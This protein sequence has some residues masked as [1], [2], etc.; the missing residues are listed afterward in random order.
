MEKR[1]ERA[2]DFSSYVDERARGFSGRGWV[3]DELARWRADPAGARYFLLTGEPGCGKTAIAARLV[4]LSESEGRFQ[5]AVDAHHFCSTSNVG[6][7]APLTFVESLSSH[8]ARRHPT[9]S[10]AIYERLG[11]RPRIS[12]EQHVGASSG[13][14][15]NVSIGHLSVGDM[16][17]EDA[18]ARLI[19]EPLETLAR[20][21]PDETVLIAID[22]L[23]EALM[24]SGGKIIV[25][26]IAGSN[27]LPPNVRFV[28]TSRSVGH[29]EDMFFGAER[30]S[31]SS[32]ER[33]AQ[34][35]NDVRLYVEW[36]LAHDEALVPRAKVLAPKRLHE[37]INALVARADG[38]FL[39]ARSLLNALGQGHHTLEIP[40]TWPEDLDDSFRDSL[41]R[42][43]RLNQRDWPRDYAPIVGVLSVAQAPL[44]QAQLATFTALDETALWSFLGELDQFVEVIKPAA[45][46]MNE[47][48]E[49]S[50]GD[51]TGER[52]YRLYHQS[53]IDFLRRQWLGRGG[54]PRNKYYLDAEAWHRRI[55]EHYLASGTVDLQNI[56]TYGFE[57]LAIHLYHARRPARLISLIDQAW[58]ELRCARR[59]GSY[60]GFF[61]DVGLAWQA[62]LDTHA[63]IPTLVRLQAAQQ[64]AHD[65][66]Y[67]YDDDDLRLLVL[68]GRPEEALARAHDRRVP[69]LRLDCLKAT[70]EAMA[71]RGLQVAGVVTEMA[72]T[73]KAIKTSGHCRDVVAKLVDNGH[74]EEAQ[75]IAEIA[76]DPEERAFVLGLIGVALWRIDP[77]QGRVLLD[78][79]GFLARGIDDARERSQALGNYA[80]AL[81][82]SGLR[83]EACAA[84]HDVPD[85]WRRSIALGDVASLLFKAGDRQV[86]SLLEESR[87][88]ASGVEEL[89]I[90]SWVL[91]R[92]SGQFAEVGLYEQA[93]KVAQSVP[94][95]DERVRARCAVARALTDVG[96]DIGRDR[97]E[98]IQSEILPGPSQSELLACLVPSLADA[99]FHEEAKAVADGC[100]YRRRDDC[101]A[102]IVKSEAE[103]ER[104][105]DALRTA[106]LI[107]S[108]RTRARAEG[109]VARALAKA[110]Q[111]LRAREICLSLGDELERASVLRHLS[112]E[113]ARKGQPGDAER[114]SREARQTDVGLTS[115][116]SRSLAIT[117][118]GVVAAKAG[119]PNAQLLFERAAS[120]AKDTRDGDN[121]CHAQRVLAAGLARSGNIPRARLVA[122]GIDKLPARA[123]S[124]CEVA[125]SVRDDRALAIELFSEA[126]SAAR[127]S[128]YRSPEG[129]RVLDGVGAALAN[130]GLMEQSAQVLG[131]LV[132]PRSRSLTL[133]ALSEYH[134]RAGEYEEA[135]VKAEQIEEPIRQC[136]AFARLAATWATAA[137][138]K[139]EEALALA[140][141]LALSLP[142]GF[143]RSYAL[144]QVAVAMHKVGDAR[145]EETLTE[146]ERAARGLADAERSKAMAA[147]ADAFVQVDRVD[148]ALRVAREARHLPY[149]DQARRKVFAALLSKERYADALTFYGLTTIDEYVALIAVATQFLNRSASF[150]LDVASTAL[151]VASWVRTD[152]H[153]L[154]SLL[155][156]HLERRRPQAQAIVEGIQSVVD[157]RTARTSPSND[158]TV[159]LIQQKHKL[160]ETSERAIALSTVSDKVHAMSEKSEASQSPKV[161]VSYSYDSPEHKEWVRKLATDL[162]SMG[163]DIVLDQWEPL[164]T[165]LARFMEQSVSTSNRV[166]LVC[167]EQ[168]SR[169]AN[170]VSGG[171]AYEKN[172][173]NSRHRIK[174]GNHQIY[175]N[176][177]KQCRISPH[178]PRIHRTKILDRFF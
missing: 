79:A 82:E 131:E 113:L 99:G 55:A 50:E 8:L 21:A 168:Y 61:A 159:V 144:T 136:Y 112:L 33:E 145:T 3:F 94:A 141:T 117:E 17:P 178:Y 150:A 84:A 16:Q 100:A 14:A 91:R 51:T 45:P 121:R 104:F 73:I 2:I 67:A 1:V 103:A 163:I 48:N 152:W 173:C 157:A 172:D 18:F 146:A 95:S 62:A 7:V 76:S 97:F 134:A 72:E 128:M 140:K 139:A 9:F 10:Q 109:R 127:T 53:M 123:L 11:G 81:A 42:A 36:R 155:S 60:A 78:R 105:E 24:A 177:Q 27:H 138:P 23:D 148:D 169:K 130:A 120:E 137:P 161:F 162:R 43:V 65:S 89:R 158:A 58:S 64:V 71:E 49:G 6:S 129:V 170:G 156:S 86:S 30:L 44:T 165:D 90:Q 101:L 108:A 56:D 47:D 54:P 25:A 38:N 34:S 96:R 5:G 75:R 116:Y 147:L 114:C 32:P 59:S 110:G 149:Y 26:L 133:C 118:L 98:S 83:E 69:E 122:T 40:P 93:D 77:P 125:A 164:G 20:S 107:K 46:V 135:R 87:V 119:H 39:Y 154:Y 142:D 88:V 37:A 80:I 175:S 166:I 174:H 102:I 68:L 111:S 70:Y 13:S 31:L 35:H 12:A 153:E 74:I 167:S 15:T 92:L 28:L 126:R 143:E 19:L 22:A 176:H 66:V 85:A 63:D 29:V 106:R 115:S 52:R 57:S 171:V 41:D 4:Q 132:G 151:E 124:L 160:S